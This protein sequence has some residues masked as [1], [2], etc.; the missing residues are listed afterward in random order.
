M[1]NK[2]A[3]I[4]TDICTNSVAIRGQ[5]KTNLKTTKV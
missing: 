1:I 4:E 5:I 3:E 2:Q